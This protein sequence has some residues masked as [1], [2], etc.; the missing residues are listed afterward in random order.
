MLI[1]AD[2]DAH[3]V[4]ASSILILRCIIAKQ[5]KRVRDGDR[6]WYESDKHFTQEQIKQIKKVKMA[7]ILCDSGDKIEVCEFEMKAMLLRLFRLV[8]L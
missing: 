4:V 6:F 5:F 3:P 1:C 8:C 7:N 2:F